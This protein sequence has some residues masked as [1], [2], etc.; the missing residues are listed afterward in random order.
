[1]GAP[2]PASMKVGFRL[3]SRLPAPPRPRPR[4]AARTRTGTA[5]PMATP[6]TAGL[7]RSTTPGAPPTGTRLQRRRPP[8]TAARVTAGPSATAN[9]GATARGTTRAE[10]PIALLAHRCV[11]EGLLGALV[12]LDPLDQ[13]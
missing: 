4:P 5:T 13:P 2:Q 6:R 3:M 9:P 12:D 7:R 10:S 1:M 8:R 11:L